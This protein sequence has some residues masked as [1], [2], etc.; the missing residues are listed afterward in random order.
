MAHVMMSI[1]ILTMEIDSYRVAEWKLLI[2]KILM[3]QFVP[4]FNIFHHQIFA[5]YINVIF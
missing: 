5:P 2:G 1:Q 4:F 3:N